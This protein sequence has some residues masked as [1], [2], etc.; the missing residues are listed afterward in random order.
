M[1]EQKLIEPMLPQKKTVD[2][3][4][5]KQAKRISKLIRSQATK[6]KTQSL[7][8]QK[9][10]RSMSYTVGRYVSQ[11]KLDASN[12]RPAESQEELVKRVRAAAGFDEIEQTARSAS[13]DYAPHPSRSHAYHAAQARGMLNDLT[14]KD[15]WVVRS[16]TIAGLRD[17][18]IYDEVE[19]DTL[20]AAQTN[21]RAAI[22]DS[23]D[24]SNE[25]GTPETRKL[26]SITITYR[27]PVTYRV[28]EQSVSTIIGNEI[29]VFRFEDSRPHHGTASDWEDTVL[30]SKSTVL[31]F[32]ELE[33]ANEE[34]EESEDDAKDDDEDGGGDDNSSSS[35]KVAPA[36]VAAAKKT[37]VKKTATKKATK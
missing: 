30:G 17:R 35:E 26:A 23:F 28:S 16:Q 36:K 8:Q 3:L 15:Q 5:N 14:R 11:K 4:K 7:Q 22:R 24:D 1:T 34:Q 6:L 29:E 25:Y 9:K 20:S 18:K 13:S 33:H 32:K 21:A 37:P 27:G 31:S 2:C 10:P 12:K 19:F